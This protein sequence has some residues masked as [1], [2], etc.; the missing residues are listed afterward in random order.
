M[1]FKFDFCSK[2]MKAILRIEIV[3]LFF[4][5]FPLDYANHFLTAG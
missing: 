2:R 5:L 1:Q 4:E 3:I